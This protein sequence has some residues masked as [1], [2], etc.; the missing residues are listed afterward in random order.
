ML[1][2]VLGFSL[3]STSECSSPSTLGCGGLVAC[4]DAIW[5]FVGRDGIG[6]S[7]LMYSVGSAIVPWYVDW[8]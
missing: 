3:P 1:L 7:S 8:A 2:S 4:N 5:R 6:E